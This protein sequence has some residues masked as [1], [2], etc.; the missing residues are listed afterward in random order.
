MERNLPEMMPSDVWNKINI[1]HLDIATKSPDTMERALAAAYYRMRAESSFR[2][3]DRASGTDFLKKSAAILQDDHKGLSSLG[4]IAA[5]YNLDSLATRFFRRAIQL[6]PEYITAYANLASLA[7]KKN[8]IVEAKKLIDTAE[9]INPLH[10]LVKRAKENFVQMQNRLKNSGNEKTISLKKRIEL[11]HKRLKA[12][13]GQAWLWNDLGTAW[14][15]SGKIEQAAKCWKKAAK[16]K[17]DY[18]RPHKNLAVYY[19]R[20][21]Q[22]MAMAK[23]HREK[24]LLLSGKTIIQPDPTK[25]LPDNPNP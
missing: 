7:L 1:R 4:S 21:K 20:E 11:L 16:L 3:G 18:A 5:A 19:E 8:K 24:Y 23:M 22:D 15:Q 2:F 17:D 12:E 13:P 14:A 10:F 9:K 6:W 25:I